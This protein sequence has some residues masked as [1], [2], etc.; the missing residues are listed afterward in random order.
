[1]NQQYIIRLQRDEAKRHPALREWFGERRIPS[2]FCLRL[3]GRWWVGDQENWVLSTQ[4]FPMKAAAPMP[5]ETPLQASTLI[6]MLGSQISRVE[7][8]ENSNVSIALSDG[9]VLTVQG[10][11]EQWEESWFLE[12]PV[13]DPDR[14][15]WS[16]V[17]NSQ[18]LIA[19]RFPGTASV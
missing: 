11:N 15:E 5:I 7:V 13:D 6:M 18:G 2:L 4:K 3:R 1:M 19:G 12:L 9:R 8:G 10:V 17:C 14:E 16:I